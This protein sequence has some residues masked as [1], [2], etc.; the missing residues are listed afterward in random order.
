MKIDLTQAGLWTLMIGTFTLA[1]T[2]TVS[3]DHWFPFVMVGRA[4]NWKTPWVLMLALIAGVG[5]V[6]TSVAIGMV[7]VFAE[8]GTSKEVAE[9]LENA[10]R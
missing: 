9:F 10:T 2:H 3:P 1:A 4:N 7:G 8:S 6:G 5:H